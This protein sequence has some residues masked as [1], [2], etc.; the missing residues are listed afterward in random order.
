MKQ[1]WN[2][3]HKRQQRKLVERPKRRH[4]QFNEKKSEQ[5]GRR[6]SDVSE[7]RKKE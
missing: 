4:S 7:K 5:K 3:V 2:N 6:R 1:S